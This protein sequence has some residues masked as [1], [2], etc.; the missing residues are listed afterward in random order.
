MPAVH[1]AA[2]PEL[3]DGLHPDADPPALAPSRPALP[4]RRSCAA[5]RS[6]P[7]VPS[8]PSTRCVVGL[9]RTIVP[10]TIAGSMPLGCLP[11]STKHARPR[12]CPPPPPLLH[13]CPP[14]FLSFPSFLPGPRGD[15][16]AGGGRGPVGAADPRPLR[17]AEQRPV[18]EDAHARAQGEKVA[19]PPGS[20]GCAVQCH[21][22]RTGNAGEGRLGAWAALRRAVLFWSGRKA[23]PCAPALT[24]CALASPYEKPNAAT[25]HPSLLRTLT[26]AHPPPTTTTTTTH[27]NTHPTPHP[28]PRSPWRTPT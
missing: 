9:Y 22:G 20:M 24:R 7:S 17:G 8:P 6:A 14:S 15:R 27:T 11:Q 21:A 26:H 18:Q 13:L 23:A 19:R 25:P 28:P 12:L 1:A 5:R 16:V 3:E 10:Y 4:A 2:V